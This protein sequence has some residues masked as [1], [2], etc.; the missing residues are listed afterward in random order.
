MDENKKLSELLAKGYKVE[1]V[2]PYSTCF[3]E[4]Y[5]VYNDMGEIGNKRIII[6]DDGSIIGKQG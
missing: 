1:I 4:K 6:D 5:Y 3:S 2:N